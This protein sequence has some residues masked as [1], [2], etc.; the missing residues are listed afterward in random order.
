MI[1]QQQL[2]LLRNQALLRWLLVVAWM[3]LIFTLSAQ[4]R[5]PRLPEPLADVLLKKTAHFLEYGILATLIWR[6]LAWGRR[7]WL[8][9][10]LLAVLYASSDEWHQS[11]VPG[12]HP[13]PWD[14]VIDGCGAATLLLISWLRMR[15]TT[16]DQ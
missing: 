1:D 4:P 6:A 14:V 13:S 3:I 5:L 7:A 8:W 2:R 15:R 10:W 9:A 16:N 12:R 11:F